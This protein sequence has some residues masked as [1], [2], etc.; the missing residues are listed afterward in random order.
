MSAVLNHLSIQF[1][2]DLRERAIL[3]VFYIIPL[4]F[5]AVM[6]A[7]FSSINVGT[8]ETL[9]ASMIIF[10]T[11]MGAVLGMP[12]PL[13]TMRES[14]VLRAYRVNGIPGAA[15]L[16]V[17]A[18][19]AFL[20]LFIVSVI[21]VF[22]APFLF[23]AAQ[24]QDFGMFFLVLICLLFTNI[25]IGLLIG[26][27]ARSQ[28]SATML[29]QAVFMPSLLLSG[30]MFPASMLPEPFLWLG[31]VFPA[32]HVMQAFTGLAFGLDTQ[33]SPPLALAVCV[34]IGVLAGGAAFSRCAAMSRA[35]S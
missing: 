30:I 15:V 12:G 10:G 3:L 25:M 18:C 28:S 26:V 5:Y 6:G 16:L 33:I 24:P 23:G 1:K 20:H 35:L 19:S 17:Q 34:G 4:I 32:T 11:T 31:R 8:K 21:I 14:G 22:S 2:M 7:V 13:I 29:S 9:S 27:T